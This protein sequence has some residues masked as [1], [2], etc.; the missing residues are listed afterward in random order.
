[1]KYYIIAGESSGDLHGGNLIKALQQN[2]HH[3]E[4]RAWGGERMRSKGATIVKDIK[5]LAYMGFWEVFT[6]LFTIFKNISF[7]KKDILNFNPDVVILIDYPGFNLRIAKFLHKHG[8]KVVYYISPQVW[9]WKKGRVKTIG[10]VVDK[11]LVI[12]PFE[13]DFYRKYGIDATFVGH[14]LLD[15]IRQTKAIDFQ[16]FVRQNRLDPKKEIIALLPGSRRQEVERMLHVML[17]TM[18]NFKN[19]QFV[20]ACANSLPLDF[21]QEICKNHKVKL[22]QGKTYG[23]LQVAS[24]AMVTSGT[25]TLETALFC[26]PEV[27]CY[28]GSRLSY[29]IAKHLVDIKFIS[30]VNLIMNRKVVTELIQDNLTPQNITSELKAI[31]HDSTRQIR[32]LEDYSELRERLGNAGASDNAAKEI[33]ALLEK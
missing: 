33:I 24:G 20:V 21:Y 15:E 27:V 3:A 10:K 16:S 6:H 31:L 17:K 25:A 19:Y 4:I 23:L 32:L 8:I 11:L 29:I 9:A 5:D 26:V 18:P 7:C 28:S 12:L 2:D 22:V 13:K 14:P 1:M 30:L